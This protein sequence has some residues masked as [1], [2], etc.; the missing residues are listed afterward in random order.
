[1]CDRCDAYDKMTNNVDQIPPEKKANHDAHLA[2]A[3]RMSA[4]MHQAETT[5]VECDDSVAHICTDMM[6]IQTIPI[7]KEQAAYFKTKV[8]EI[9][10]PS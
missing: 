10:I 3:E 9:I 7:L 5:C 8:N 2:Q 6:Q 1:M 4:L